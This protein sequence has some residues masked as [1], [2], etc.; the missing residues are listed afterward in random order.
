MHRVKTRSRDLA[1]RIV[2]DPA[3]LALTAAV[4]MAGIYLIFWP[5]AGTDLAAQVARADATRSTGG[6]TWWGG[7]YGGISMPTYS[8]LSAQVMAVIGAQFT[9]V[10]AFL[11]C[12]WLSG[13]LMRQTHRPRAG[14]LAAV[15]GLTGNLAVGRVTFAL[16]LALALVALRF[17]QDHRH[18][19]WAALAGG[20]SAMLSPLAAM[21]LCIIAG[22]MM[23]VDKSRRTAGLFVCACAAA[24]V[25]VTTALF[26]S[27]GIQPV[28]PHSTWLPLTA[29]VILC[30]LP[31][32]RVVRLTCLFVAITI[33]GSIYIDSPIGSN[34]QRLVVVAALPV[35][36]ALVRA[37]VVAIVLGLVAV[38][39]WPVTDVR[40]SVALANEA[41]SHES[42]FEPV[43][44]MLAGTAPTGR[45]EAIETEAHWSSTYLAGIIPLARGWERQ[46]DTAINPIFYKAGE[47][48]AESYHQWLLENSVEWVAL[49]DTRPDWGSIGEAGLIATGLPYLQEVWDT[50]HWR[51][52]RV[53]DAAPVAPSPATA[54]TLE[55][56]RVT[57]TIGAPGALRLRVRWSPQ[58]Q[59]DGPAGC[60]SDDDGWINLN[61][62]LPG[63]YTLRGGF[64]LAK[65]IGSTGGTVCTPGYVR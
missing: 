4:L 56:S 8:I 49:P 60:V 14:A 28:S 39:A 63:T 45:L 34:T 2:H 58:L 37:P 62:S 13:G 35:V 24:P 6:S 25:I 30:L 64:S 47:L 31:V 19:V 55:P 44:S 61:V 52:F 41:S 21:F 17:V 46:T 38:L 16:G 59:L 22:A 65:G 42:Y 3:L 7:W 43:I 36:V 33:V 27:A 18:P 54:S 10:V 5:N 48:N 57:V 32:P 50:Q 15:V 40:Q 29:L 53:T 9:G 11:A 12:C 1:T 23:L 20:G 51:F 26:P